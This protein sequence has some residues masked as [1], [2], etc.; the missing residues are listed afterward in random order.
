MLNKTVAVLRDG[1]LQ[2]AGRVAGGDPYQDFL[3]ITTGIFDFA[4]QMARAK[5]EQHLQ[6]LIRSH[7]P[8]HTTYTPVSHQAAALEMIAGLPQHQRLGLW[9]RLSRS[10][11]DGPAFAIE[12]L[13]VGLET[14]TRDQ[15]LKRESSFQ[16]SRDSTWLVAQL[17]RALLQ[18]HALSYADAAKIR[19]LSYPA[20]RPF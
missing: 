8:R 16:L 20:P 14:A 4:A 17:Q 13:P 3:A 11:N 10:Q 7:N 18:H 2:A 1:F 9:T 19:A 12:I 15:W 5:T 6:I